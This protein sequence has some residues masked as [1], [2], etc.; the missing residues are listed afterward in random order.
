[1]IYESFPSD[2][3]DGW[4]ARWIDEQLKENSKWL[5][6]KDWLG[7]WREVKVFWLVE[8]MCVTAVSRNEMIGVEW[9]NE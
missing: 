3:R 7:Q 8:G 6:V 2:V 1:M 9:V 5:K 4:T